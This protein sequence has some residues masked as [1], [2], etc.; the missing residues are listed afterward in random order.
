MLSTF[1][2]VQIMVNGEAP[3]QVS[4]VSTIV[5]K[6]GAGE[7]ARGQTI[8]ARAQPPHTIEANA[9]EASGVAKGPG[10]R[11]EFGQAGA[12]EAVPCKWVGDAGG[13]SRPM[14]PRASES[15]VR[16]PLSSIVGTC[17]ELLAA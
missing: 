5:T 1:D 11:S 4:V 10:G 8:G 14:T 7:V 17:W 6:V 13:H 3:L 16:V 15:A 9:W 2:Y 12:G